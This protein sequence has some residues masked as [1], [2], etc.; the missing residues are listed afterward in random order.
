MATKLSGRRLR[1]ASHRVRHKQHLNGAARPA[2]SFFVR[3]GVRERRTPVPTL[4]KT[5]PV[6][7]WSDML[8]IRSGYNPAKPRTVLMKGR[9]EEPESQKCLL[10]YNSEEE[11]EARAL[12]WK[13]QRE[14]MEMCDRARRNDV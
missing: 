4:N 1:A 8:T 3:A 10:V 14:F 13:P 11:R 2:A 12:G 6:A 5:L 9:P 7:V